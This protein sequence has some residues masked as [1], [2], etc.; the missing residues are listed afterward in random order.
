M[1]V[2]A[3]GGNGTTSVMGFRGY[4]GVSAAAQ[5]PTPKADKSKHAKK[6]FIVDLFEMVW[7]SH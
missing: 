1:S 3:P 6:R 4:A 5:T 7:T 2:D